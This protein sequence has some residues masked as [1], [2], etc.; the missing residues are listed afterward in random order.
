MGFGAAKREEYLN[1][2]LGSGTPATIYL[3]VFLASG[4]VNLNTGAGTEPSTGSYARLAIANNRTNF[5]LATT[6]GDLT[7]ILNGTDLIM[8]NP[9]ASSGLCSHWGIWDAATGGSWRCGAALEIPY[10]PTP[11]QQLIFEVGRLGQV[12]DL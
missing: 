12:L 1:D 6:V 8:W 9:T 3:G 5:P 2:L 7:E 10:N 4:L 11:N